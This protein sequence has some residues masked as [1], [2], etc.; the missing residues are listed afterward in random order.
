MFFFQKAVDATAFAAECLE[1]HNQLRVKHG[2]PPLKLSRK[3]CQISKEWADKLAL[4][5]KIEHSNNKEY[6]E[7]IFGTWSSDP[8]Y[9]I[10]GRLPVDNW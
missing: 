4:R 6:G 7:N 2:A 3:I 10:D 1:A 8:S 9:S 5:G